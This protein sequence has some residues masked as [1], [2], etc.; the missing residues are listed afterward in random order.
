MIKD[1]GIDE[2]SFAEHLIKQKYPLTKT[3]DS[4]LANI[5]NEF[6]N[7]LPDMCDPHVVL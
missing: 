5:I 4:S 3:V 1:Q 6:I 2:E 7:S